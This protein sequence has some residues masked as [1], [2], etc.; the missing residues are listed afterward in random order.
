MELLKYRVKEILESKSVTD[1]SKF[2]HALLQS[3]KISNSRLTQLLN[4]KLEDNG[5]W[6]GEQL[7]IAAMV[8]EVSIEDLYP[9]QKVA[10]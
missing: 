6:Q 4:L 2:R 5:D 10:A 7:R 9:T 8:L 1:Y 3:M